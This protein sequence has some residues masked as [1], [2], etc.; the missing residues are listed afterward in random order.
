MGVPPWTLDKLQLQALLASKALFVSDKLETLP[1]M[2]GGPTLGGKYYM[3]HTAA[4]YITHG[5]MANSCA[6]QLFTEDIDI[7]GLISPPN[8]NKFLPQQSLVFYT[9]LGSMGRNIA[10]CQPHKAGYK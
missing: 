1:K 9:R 6:E 4:R 3:K 5:S 7:Q 10:L 2:K 8:M